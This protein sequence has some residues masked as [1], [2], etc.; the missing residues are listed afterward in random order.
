M[1]DMVIRNGQIYDGSG[2]PPFRGDVAIDGGRITAV[3]VVEGPG[4]EEIDAG[5]HAVTPGFVDVHTHYDAQVLWN[6][7][8]VPSSEHGVT[9]VVMGN[10]S[11]GLAPCKSSQRELLLKVMAG[12]EDIPEAVMTEG[13]NWEWETFPE[14]LDV[15]A[16]RRCDIDFAAQLPHSCLRVYVMGKRG[17][18]R[19]IATVA[20]LAQMTALVEEAMAAGAIGIS[21]SHSLAH[22]SVDGSLAPAET[23]EETELLALARGLRKAPNGVIEYI[24]DLPGL[25]YGD[26]SGFEVMR[27]MAQ[28]ADKPLSFTLVQVDT[29]PEG[30]RRLL[31]LIE[32]ANA[33]GVMMRGQVAARAVGISY[34]LDL[35]FNPFSYRK[36]YV[37][38]EDL[39]LA[40]RVE[41]MRDP[42]RRARILSETAE[43]GNHHVL[44]LI[45]MVDN[46]YVM[47][48]E[49]DYEPPPSRSLGAIAAA[50]GISSSELAYDILLEQGGRTMLYLPVTNY[51]NGTLDSTLEM[52]RHPHTVV[53]LGDGGAHYGL[54]CDAA[55][56][57]F[58]LS[59]WAR[60]R[61][62]ARMAVEEIIKALTSDTA[63]SVGLGDR[64]LIRPGLIAD[65]NIV[66]LERI[67]LNMPEVRYDLPTG[68]RRMAQT[69]DGYLATIKTGIVTYRDGKHSGALPG[70]LVRSA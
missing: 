69:A 9:T 10:C 1:H 30:Y 63:A 25:P 14:Y 45:S 15:L 29:W 6:D 44:W 50:K 65:L 38:I 17:A 18:D 60:D 33:E 21:S 53:S 68:A 12:V 51:C 23:A 7:R 32:Q 11:V 56:P 16:K 41:A 64:G 54:I 2:S 52:M 24:S 58:M 39:P 67:R 46:M 20:D 28:E 5:G 55:Y 70:R 57:S 19:E 13:L 49:F 43:H 48:S 34:G 3:G 62:G 40:Q 59:H 36:S 22:R 37:E 31:E 27:R 4:T 47:D 42:A 61:K 26:I 8:L 66:D 35:S